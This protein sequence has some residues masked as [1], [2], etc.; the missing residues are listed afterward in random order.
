MSNQRK[1]HDVLPVTPRVMRAADAHRS[2]PMAVAH[3]TAIRVR[4]KLL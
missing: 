3:T 2:V 4:K 1:P